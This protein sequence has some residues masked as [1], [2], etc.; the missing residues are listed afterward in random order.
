MIV[1][2]LAEHRV[3][4]PKSAGSSRVGHPTNVCLAEEIVPFR[5]PMKGEL[6]A[7]AQAEE[8][9]LVPKHLHRLREGER[10]AGQVHAEPVPLEGE[11]DKADVHVVFSPTFVW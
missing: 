1:A 6:L 9:C 10:L 5:L 2:Q 4:V 7:V 3:E 11:L 8:S